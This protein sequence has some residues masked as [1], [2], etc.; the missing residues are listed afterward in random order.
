[1]LERDPD[2]AA[3]VAAALMIFPPMVFTVTI[4]MAVEVPVVRVIVERHARD[5]H[6]G[7]GVPAV[8]FTIAG[9]IGGRCCSRYRQRGN[10]RSSKQDSEFHML[11]HFACP[12]SE[13]GTAT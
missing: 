9:H 3:P 11:L 6:A 1:M 7:L 5:R 2:A 12:E 13:R 4:P 8:A 10:G